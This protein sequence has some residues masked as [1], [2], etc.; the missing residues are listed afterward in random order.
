MTNSLTRTSY[1]IHVTCANCLNW[2]VVGRIAPLSNPRLNGLT[3][4][5]ANMELPEVAKNWFAQKP[6]CAECRTTEG[7]D[8]A[9]TDLIRLVAE[10]S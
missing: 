9:R 4:A 6:T 8:P 2:R 3:L 10:F 5:E 1:L 7:Y